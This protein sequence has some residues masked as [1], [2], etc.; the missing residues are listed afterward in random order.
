MRVSSMGRRLFPFVHRGR[1]VEALPVRPDP[2]ASVEVAAPDGV[3]AAPVA[4]LPTPLVPPRLADGTVGWIGRPLVFAG[5]A[6]VL[7]LFRNGVDGPVA[8]TAYLRATYSERGA[9]QALYVWLAPVLGGPWQ[10]P[11]IFTDDQVLGRYLAR[12][13]VAHLPGLHGLGFEESPT[14]TATFDHRDD[15]TIGYLAS[16]TVGAHRI[17]ALWREPADRRV[18]Q[19]RGVEMGSGRMDLTTLI[20][21]CNAAELAIDGSRIEGTLR[22]DPGDDRSPSSAYVMVGTAWTEPEPIPPAPRFAR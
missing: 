13:I 22:H 7:R 12:R 11:A 15:L 6:P 2:S 10:G 20:V 18:I 3:P 14:E 9:G 8:V 16:V 19:V 17:T 4:V 1:R 21:P 5:D